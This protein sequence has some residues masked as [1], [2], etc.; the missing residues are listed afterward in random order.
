MRRTIKP[1]KNTDTYFAKKWNAKKEKILGGIQKGI[2]KAADHPEEWAKGICAL[3][4]TRGTLG[5]I[6]GEECVKNVL[7]SPSGVKYQEN[8]RAVVPGNITIDD[9]DD[10][11]VKRMRAGAA[12]GLGKVTQANIN[13]GHT[14]WTEA[15]VNGRKYRRSKTGTEVQKAKAEL[16]KPTT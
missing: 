13:A 12:E 3:A 5:N 1:Y 4:K 6:T 15:V 11:A 10:E 2:L 16:F 7:A 8:L 14:A 9:I